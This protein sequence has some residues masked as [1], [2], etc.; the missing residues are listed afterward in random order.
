MKMNWLVINQFMTRPLKDG[1]EI[2]EVTKELHG[3][4]SYMA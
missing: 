3:Y 2:I 4:K 1:A